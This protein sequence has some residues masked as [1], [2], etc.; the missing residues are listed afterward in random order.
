MR[1]EASNQR[2][3]A[4]VMQNRPANTGSALPQ[5]PAPGAT[6]WNMNGTENPSLFLSTRLNTFSTSTLQAAEEMRRWQAVNAAR[7]ADRGRTADVE[8]EVRTASERDDED[9]LRVPSDQ[10]NLAC[11]ICQDEIALGDRMATLRCQH[12][13]HLNCVDTYC[14]HEQ[15]ED[16]INTRQ[17]NCPICRA[18]LEVVCQETY[19]G[20]PVTV[21]QGVPPRPTNLSMATPDQSSGSSSRFATP[22]QQTTPRD[23][24]Y[25][26][27]SEE[28]ATAYHTATQLPDGRL[29]ILIDPGAWTNLMGA[30]LARK[31]AQRALRQGLKPTQEE[32]P[33]PLTVSG[34]GSGS[35]RCQYKMVCPIAVPHE[36]SEARLHHFDTPIVEGSGSNL[37]G[38]LGLRSL[39]EQRAVLDM[40][41]RKL[42]LPG[43]GEIEVVLPP[44]S[45]SIP[46]EKAPSGHLVMPVDAFEKL[47]KKES[48]LPERTVQLHSAEADP[49]VQT[50]EPVLQSQL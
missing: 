8:I 24:T 22:M 21:D 26:V 2:R 11:A 31:L 29:S 43:P 49:E 38:L 39:E 13:F 45:I 1:S 20:T 28:V 3:V 42:Y 6:I 40:G 14:A 23:V 46:L 32:M 17:P 7:L 37:P 44:G 15:G 25:P 16:S 41:N 34:V 4:S 9:L 36:G 10:S 27:W 12:T 5:A 48:G 30:N 47:A 18:N 50:A 35:Q 19:M 33:N